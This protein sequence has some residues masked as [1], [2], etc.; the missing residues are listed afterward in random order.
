MITQEYMKLPMITKNIDIEAKILSSGN[1]YS[2]TK[3]LKKLY[4]GVEQLKAA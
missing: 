2:K 3:S 1:R 4:E